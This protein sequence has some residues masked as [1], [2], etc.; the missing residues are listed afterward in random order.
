[1]TEAP[2]SEEL[3]PHTVALAAAVRNFGN[4]L[5][6]RPL[7][8]ERANEI[9][10]IL[11]DLANEVEAFPEISKMD[12][13]GRRN[14]INTYLETGEWPPAPP[15]GSQLEFDPSSV[16]GGELNPFGMGATY[17][18][19]GEEVVGKVNLAKC[20]E[21]PPERV[22]GG[23]VCAI[24]DEVMGSVFRATGTASALT[25]ELTVRFVGPAPLVEDLQFRARQDEAVGRRRLMSGEATTVDGTVF[26]TATATFIEMKAEHLPT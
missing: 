17:F 26:A 2:Q 5:I 10:S 4:A 13:L 8:A 15:D 7:E 24:F 6:S 21:G 11:S 3:P 22:H 23:V 25:G 14:R 19:D 18:K 9:A 16:V 1:M 12:A 20:F